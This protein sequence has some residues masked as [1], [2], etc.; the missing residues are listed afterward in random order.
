MAVYFAHAMRSLQYLNL[1]QHVCAIWYDAGTRLLMICA[2]WHSLS[3][4]TVELY[5]TFKGSMTH[6]QVLQIFE[7]YLLQMASDIRR[8]F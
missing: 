3:P 5:S 6:L 8:I 2:A 1:H 4:S 7:K